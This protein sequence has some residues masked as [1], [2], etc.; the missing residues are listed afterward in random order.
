MQSK[1]LWLD[2]LEVA[3]AESVWRDTYK[4]DIDD[5]RRVLAMKSPE[6]DNSGPNITQM[7]ADIINVGACRVPDAIM[8][9]RHELPRDNDLL[10]KTKSLAHLPAM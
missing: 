2:K 1:N 6:S 3:L 10:P 7:I 9:C 4:Q 5:L 8:N